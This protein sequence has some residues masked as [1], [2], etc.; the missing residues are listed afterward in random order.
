MSVFIMLNKKTVLLVSLFFL[1]VSKKP[2]IFYFI[3]AR[4]FLTHLFCYI[5]KHMRSVLHYHKSFLT[6]A[7]IELKKSFLIFKHMVWYISQEGRGQHL[8]LFLLLYFY[9]VTQII[10]FKVAVIWGIFFSFSFLLKDFILTLTVFKCP[11]TIIVLHLPNSDALI[12]SF[13]DE[14][15]NL[16]YFPASVYI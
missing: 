5:L 1:Y 13:F 14:G 6:S 3:T 15:Q 16:T 8:T 10:F 4:H 11:C 7:A 9:F 12:H 2:L